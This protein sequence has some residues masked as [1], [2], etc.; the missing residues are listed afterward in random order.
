MTEKRIWPIIGVFIFGG[1]LLQSFIQLDSMK[2]RL[3]AWITLAIVGVIYFLFV[4]LSKKE[5][6]SWF[7]GMTALA[8]VSVLMIFLQ[9][10]IFH[11]GH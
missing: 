6:K 8:I 5:S 3:E 4:S 1:I 10:M 11:T 2:Y 7:I 9:P